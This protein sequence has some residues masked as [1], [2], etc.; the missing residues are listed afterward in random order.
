MGNPVLTQKCPY[1]ISIIIYLIGSNSKHIL[2][3]YNVLSEDVLS[4][5]QC[6]RLIVR[7]GFSISHLDG[8]LFFLVLGLLA[9][10]AGL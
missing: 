6:T 8:L 5:L 10:P 1:Q 7:V 4:N 2:T 9:G 3:R